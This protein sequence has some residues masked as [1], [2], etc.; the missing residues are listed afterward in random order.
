MPLEPEL[1]F[2]LEF[3]FEPDDFVFEPLDDDFDDDDVLCE[4]LFE[5]FRS[6]NDEI[7][8]AG[9]PTVVSI[10]C[11]GKLLLIVALST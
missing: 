10:D 1:L 9:I 7:F 8:V 5:S 3:V 4:R 2:V 6:F 11:I